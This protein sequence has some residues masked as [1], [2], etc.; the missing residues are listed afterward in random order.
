MVERENSFIGN[1]GNNFQKRLKIQKKNQIYVLF[2]NFFQ[3]WFPKSISTLK[4][5]PP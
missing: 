1:S 5:E 3:S 4:S 2:L